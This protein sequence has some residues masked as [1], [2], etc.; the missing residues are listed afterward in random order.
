[1]DVSEE[2]ILTYRLEN[3]ARWARERKPRY[4]GSLFAIMRDLG[5]KYEEGKKETPIIVDV[6]DALEIEAAWAKMKDGIEKRL[7][8]EVYGSDEPLWIQC[9]NAG[10]RPRKFNYY[11]RRAKCYLHNILCRDNIRSTD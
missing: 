1:M 3:W 6:K 10:I 9:R 11:M 7:L 4:R 2:D 8:Q 5:F